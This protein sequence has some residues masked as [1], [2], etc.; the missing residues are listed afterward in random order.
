MRDLSR[1]V[2]HPAVSQEGFASLAVPTYHASAIVFPGA[3][4]YAHR[5]HRGTDGYSY[6]L[7]GAPPTRTLEAQLSAL[8]GAERTMLLPSGQAAITVVFL[9]VLLPGDRVPIPDTA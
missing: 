4:A 9:S 7:H 6:G 2:H 5:K 1:C 3:E 8:H